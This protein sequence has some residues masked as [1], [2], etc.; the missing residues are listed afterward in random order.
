MD[1]TTLVLLGLAAAC[2]WLSRHREAF[3]APVTFKDF[4]PPKKGKVRAQIVGGARTADVPSYFVQLWV[5]GKSGMQ[6]FGGGALITPSIVLTA[7]HCLEPFGVR[8]GRVS[9]AP[10]LVC[11]IQGQQYLPKRVL[12][13]PKY[14]GRSNIFSKSVAATQ[15]DLCLILIDRASA[16]PARINS[17]PSKFP[18][19]VPLVMMG[20]GLEDPSNPQSAG[21]FKTATGVSVN[22]SWVP[23][24][25]I[26]VRPA[27]ALQGSACH[28]DSGGPLVYTPDSG[29]DVVVGIVHGAGEPSDSCTLGL[30]A[31][32]GPNFAWILSGIRTLVAG[33]KISAGSA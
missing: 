31:S 17:L 2:M 6:N 24:G 29:D 16:K 25:G 33:T 9:L 13:H 11:V 3:E 18:P 12:M 26:G 23:A 15:H 10:G 28:G 8:P 5:N 32:V 30:Y 19:N 14:P 20:N 1:R 21:G 22:A 4:A 7:A 27:G